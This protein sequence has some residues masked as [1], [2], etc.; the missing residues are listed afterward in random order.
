M[1]ISTLMCYF[2]LDFLHRLLTDMSNNSMQSVDC[3][4]LCQGVSGA[5]ESTGD[6]VIGE[7]ITQVI[8]LDAGFFGFVVVHLCEEDF[9]PVCRDEADFVEGFSPTEIPEKHEL[10]GAD[11]IK[12]H[13]CDSI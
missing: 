10:S 11:R 9:I 4:L 12:M 6:A 3:C 13:V 2:L 1:M 5:V 7:K 8:L